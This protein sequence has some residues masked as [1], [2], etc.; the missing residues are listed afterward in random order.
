MNPKQMK[1]M[2]KRMGIKSDEV[3]A[4]QVII[5]C[6]DKEIIIDN[7]QVMATVIQGQTMFQIQGDVRESQKDVEADISAEDV[8]MV[9]E[10][11]KVNEE[12][13]IS[14]LESAGGDLAQAI[15][16]LKS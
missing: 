7:P 3:D 4:E 5:R 11:A 12:K 8:E 15:L 6:V 1:K 9:M 16:D 2:M 14:A 13:A 10:Q